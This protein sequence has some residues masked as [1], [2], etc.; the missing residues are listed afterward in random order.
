MVLVGLVGVSKFEIHA[1]RAQFARRFFCPSM[2][3]DNTAITAV[4]IRGDAPE[5]GFSNGNR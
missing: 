1:V 3:A 4:A 2:S 5:E